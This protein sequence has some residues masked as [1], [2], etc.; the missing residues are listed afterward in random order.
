MK[1]RRLELRRIRAARRY[2]AATV[3]AVVTS[4]RSGPTI[5][6]LLKIAAVKGVNASP[7]ASLSDSNP[8]EV[9]TVGLSEISGSRTPKQNCNFHG[10]QNQ[11]QNHHPNNDK[12]PNENNLQLHQTTQMHH[13]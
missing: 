1:I 11:C 9:D 5:V 7:A 13:H 3:P 6:T 4:P 8:S 10:T 2:P 12:Q